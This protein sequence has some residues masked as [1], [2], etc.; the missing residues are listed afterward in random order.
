[1]L[2]AACLRVDLL[3]MCQPVE[4]ALHVLLHLSLHLVPLVN[5]AAGRLGSLLAEL[6][7]QDAQDEIHHKKGTENNKGAEEK[8]LPTVPSRVL[9]LVQQQ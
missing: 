2:S 5:S 7:R 6:S 8:P 1:M 3:G 4:I 9:Q